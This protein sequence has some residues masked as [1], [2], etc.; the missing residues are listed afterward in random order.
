MLFYLKLVFFDIILTNSENPYTYDLS[1]RT[2][3]SL[4]YQNQKVVNLRNEAENIKLL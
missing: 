3:T 4:T 1:L 2:T